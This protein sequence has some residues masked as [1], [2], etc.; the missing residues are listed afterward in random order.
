MKK[1]PS[2]LFCILMDFIGYATYTVPLLGEFSDIIWAP[3]S[4]LIFYFSFGGKKGALG[5]L[6]NFAEEILPFTDFIPTFTITWIWQ[7]YSRKKADISS[8]SRSSQ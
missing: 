2:L 5:G 4:G 8:V 3:L 6:F 1:Q 7:Y